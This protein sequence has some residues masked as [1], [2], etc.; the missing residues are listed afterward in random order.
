MRFVGWLLSALLV[1]FP[2]L[3][4]AH[5]N[6]DPRAWSEKNFRSDLMMPA[7]R[8]KDAQTGILTKY[9]T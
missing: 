3:A 5:C 1:T 8:T 4:S 9:T 6:F 7:R 2:V